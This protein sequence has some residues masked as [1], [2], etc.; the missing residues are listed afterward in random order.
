MLKGFLLSLSLLMVI[1]VSEAQ[2]VASGSR[3]PLTYKKRQILVGKGGGFTGASTV[4]YLLENG[5]LYRKTGTDSLFTPLGKQPAATTRRL[6]KELENNC[7]IKTTPFDHPGNTYQFVG[8]KKNEREYRVTWGAS[9]QTVP[10]AFRTFYNSFM[11]LVP[12][13]GR[14]E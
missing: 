12:A 10:P 7:R 8:W 6:F 1:G 11:K 13:S 14:E 2:T 3:Y 4:Y 5:Y 9:G